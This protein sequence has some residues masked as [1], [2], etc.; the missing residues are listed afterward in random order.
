M[1]D[2]TKYSAGAMALL[3]ANLGFY[4][5]DA[6][7]ELVSY[8]GSLLE[9]SHDAFADMGIPLQPGTLA[10]D[11]DQMTLPP[12]CTAMAP[13]VPGRRSSCAALSATGKC[14]RHWRQKS[15]IYDKPITVLAMPDTQGIPTKGGLVKKFDSW[16]AEKTV[17]AS[18]FWESV[19]NGSR[20][21][22]LVELPLHRDVPAASY[23][24]LG[25]HTYRVEQTQT[26]E[27]GDGLPVTWLSLMRME[28]AYDT[29]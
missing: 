18:R 16:C 20:V 5:T 9:Y 1:A 3:K 10:D 21:D 13:P 22:K 19:A 8:W 26:G 15:M 2:S 27:D 25:G 24:R 11:M 28:D 29:Y 17:Y 14:S 23:A 12:G 6:P 4:G 7:A